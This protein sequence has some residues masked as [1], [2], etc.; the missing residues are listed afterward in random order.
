MTGRVTAAVTLV[1]AMAGLG[2]AATVL[3]AR[4]A[5]YPAPPPTERLLYLRSGKVANRLMLSFDALAADV[6]WI[7]AI[8]HY[9]RDRKTARDA[10]RFEL[11]QP[12]L[13]LT[14]T[15]DPHF[16][17]AYRFGA[18]FLAMPPGGSEER[19]AGRPDLAI[20]LLEKAL[21]NNPGQWVY[22]QDAGFIHYFNTGNYA[23]A[24]RWFD[25]AAAMPGAPAWLRPLAAEAR[26][27]GGDRAGARRMLESLTRSE[28]A[29][30]RRHA[31]RGLLQLNALEEIDTL[32]AL[33]ESFNAARHT[34]PF[35]WQ[36]LLGR[37][38]KDPAGVPYVY[39]QKTHKVSLSETASPLSPLPDALRHPTPAARIP[40]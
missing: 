2:L 11:L 30:I 36:E 27:G 7:R 40:K 14:T 33:V 32:Q 29:Y 28:E 8:Q 5:R 16:R 20:A 3:H 15:L 37:I 34:Y 10:G 24:A 9:G 13:D 18:I 1:G 21:R 35:G 17:I 23:E 38:P 12:L 25:Q 19:G 6:Y 31:E 26:L 22:A 4:D 39:D